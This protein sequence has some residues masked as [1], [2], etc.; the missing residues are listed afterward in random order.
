M[1]LRGEYSYFVFLALKMM[2]KMHSPVQEKEQK[3]LRWVSSA[4]AMRDL[5]IHK[6]PWL[7]FSLQGPFIR[8]MSWFWDR[9]ALLERLQDMFLERPAPNRCQFISRLMS[10][11][12]LHLLVRQNPVV[13]NI[14]HHLCLIQWISE[15]I[16][17]F[18]SNSHAAISISH[19]ESMA[20]WS[21][22]SNFVQLPE[23]DA[24]A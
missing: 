22:K 2:S 7:T 6:N 13:W 3:R 16:L 20:R 23:S 4:I 21:E 10:P 5:H 15:Q 19:F 1:S 17:G 9:I 12:Q 14:K 11:L 8:S 24:V 18:L